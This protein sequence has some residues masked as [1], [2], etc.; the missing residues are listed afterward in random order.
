[1]GIDN[2]KQDPTIANPDWNKVLRRLK[3]HPHEARIIFGLSHPL[4]LALRNR[5]NPVP[6]EVTDL[7]IECYPDAFMEEDIG[8]AC[9][10][11]YTRGETMSVLILRSRDCFTGKREIFKR[12][13]LDWIACNNNIEVAKALIDNNNAANLYSVRDW[14]EIRPSNVSVGVPVLP[15]K[16]ES[17]GLQ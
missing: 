7:L 12:W 4:N 14:K 16:I 10:N 6:A 3:S 11:K 9:R 2:L 5:V 13:D 15:F 1:M 17:F 8:N